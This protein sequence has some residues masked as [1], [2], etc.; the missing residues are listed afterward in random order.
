M[1]KNEK[2][3]LFSFLT[4]YVGSSVFFLAMS[5]YIYYN[6][7]LKTLDK[8]CSIEMVSAAHQ[9]RGDILKSYLNNKEYEPKELENQLLRFALFD[10]N[11]KPI[12]SQLS[13]E[14]IKFSK[15]AYETNT[16]T[17]HILELNKKEIPIK[18]IVIETKQGILDKVELKDLIW[19]I[20]VVG[21]IIITFVGYLLS[22]LLL[23]PVKE[24]ISHMDKFIKDSAH[25]LNTPIS[26][27]RTSVSMLKKGKNEEKMLGYINSST[28]QISEAYNDLH[29]AVFNDIQDSMNVSFDLKELCDESIEFFGDIALVKKVTI[30]HNLNSL[31]VFM[32]KNKAQ[33]IINNLISNAIKYSKKNGIIDISL[34]GSI[35]TI[36]D[37]GIGIS[38]EEQQ[39]IFKRYER[40][41]N[42][43]GGFGIGLDIV[44]TI[45]EEYD[46]EV[47][48]E[49]KI[50]SGSTFTLNFNSVH[51]V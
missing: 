32:D 34:Y 29:F 38:D 28:K 50:N 18:Y 30:Q 35:F 8:Q 15:E 42:N 24:K 3:A 46:I 39:I 48:L 6:K 40:G 13:T 22:N 7:E 16:H 51:E 20:L 47:E 37:Y 12:F 45:S 36:K 10:Y 27:L 25:E 2:K 31:N 26:V 44:N 5:L 43:E 33:K 11:N 49:S 14:D 19:L 9:I 4:I 1:N 21:T 17:F 41:T 23:R